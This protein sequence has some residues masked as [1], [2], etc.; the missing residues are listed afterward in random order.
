MK[1]VLEGLKNGTIQPDVLFELIYGGGLK[2]FGIPLLRDFTGYSEDAR[3]ELIELIISVKREDV[4]RDYVD[5]VFSATYS[6]SGCFDLF[7]FERSSV[8]LR[9]ALIRE[10]FL[11][12]KWGVSVISDNLYYKAA[13]GL[14]YYCSCDMF[15]FVSDMFEKYPKTWRKK[16][17]KGMLATGQQD[18]LEHFFGL[19]ISGINN[20]NKYSGNQKKLKRMT[21]LQEISRWQR[22]GVDLSFMT[23]ELRSVLSSFIVNGDASGFGGFLKE[24]G[25]RLERNL[26]V[27][28]TDLVNH[29]N[30]KKLHRQ[31]MF[32][33]SINKN[34]KQ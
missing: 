22:W 15:T 7:G 31:K 18:Q 34:L 25:I 28:L 32:L 5:Y 6:W 10:M 8:E 13:F 27:N 29:T 33:D 26:A 1:F 12:K 4:C 11:W 16:I 24:S 2:E 9:T 17:V 21:L 3:R 23:K 14:I 19:A 30:F 20:S